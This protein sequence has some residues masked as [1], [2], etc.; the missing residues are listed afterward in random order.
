MQTA[1]HAVNVARPADVT[2]SSG[3]GDQCTACAG[4]EWYGKQVVCVITSG[5]SN[6]STRTLRENTSHPWTW[7]VVQ[8]VC[9]YAPMVPAD[10]QKGIQKR[11]D[12]LVRCISERAVV[13][14]WR[15]AQFSMGY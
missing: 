14:L 1:A 15:G 8:V 9:E 6:G 7:E 5:T 11:A 12:S 3:P 13:R 2:L 10:M 4:Y